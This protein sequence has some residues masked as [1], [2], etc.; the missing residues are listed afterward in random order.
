MAGT[1]RGPK[2]NILV[3]TLIETAAVAS[4]KI[5]AGPVGAAVRFVLFLAEHIV[6][7]NAKRVGRSLFELD[8]LPLAKL[9]IVAVFET[10][11]WEVWWNLAERA[12]SIGDQAIAAA[13]L[14]VGLLV[15]HVL[16][17]NTVARLPLLR[18]VRQRIR[19]SLDFTGVETVTG[20]LW[21]RLLDVSGLL[22]AAILAVGLFVEHKTSFGRPVEGA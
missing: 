13:V 7:F 11:T 20:I 8:N 16:E 3:F 12:M 4:L 21:L 6:S 14:A 1:D 19:E 5:I 2:F 15:G 18:D 22:A 9:S 10:A 17:R